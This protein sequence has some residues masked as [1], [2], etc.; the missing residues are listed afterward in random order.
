MIDW[1]TSTHPVEYPDA[2]AAMEAHVDAMIAGNGI[3]GNAGE[4]IWLLEHPPL[5]TS[6]TSADAAELL[7]PH[8]FPV[9]KTGRGGRFTYHG[10]G[11]RV[12]YIMVDLRVRGRDVRAYVHNLEEWVIT[13]LKEFD[14]HAGRRD[15]RIGLW[16]E[17][18]QREEKIAAIGVRIRKWVTYHGVSINLNPDLGHF[19]GIVPCGLSTFGVTSLH[20]LGVPATFE[21]LDNALKTAW[22]RVF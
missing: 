7:T 18:N 22:D 16:V 12:A 15:G 1:Q 21:Q 2:L 14:I 6:G 8:R 13:A 17:H 11:Q 20:A 5:Y 9:Y 4:K 3:A 19:G 10:P